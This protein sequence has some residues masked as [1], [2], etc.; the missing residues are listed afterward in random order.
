MPQE[1]DDVEAEFYREIAELV[2]EEAFLDF[3][4]LNTRQFLDKIQKKYTRSRS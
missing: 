3:E 2:L 1:V 4:F